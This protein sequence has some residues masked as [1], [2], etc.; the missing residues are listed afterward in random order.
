MVEERN[1]GR[2]ERVVRKGT[3]EVGREEERK[4]KEEQKKE[5]QKRGEGGRIGFIRVIYYKVKGLVTFHLDPRI[6]NIW[7]HS[8]KSVP[9]I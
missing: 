1:R 2:K 3:R 9:T 7:T 8:E 4:K 5:R 6:L